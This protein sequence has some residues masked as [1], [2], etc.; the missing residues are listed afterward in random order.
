MDH[1]SYGR[2]EFYCYVTAQKIPAG[3]AG[4]LLKIDV[5]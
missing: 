3:A 5:T 2:I 1:N 4:F